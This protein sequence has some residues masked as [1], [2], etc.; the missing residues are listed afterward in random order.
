VR[1]RHHHSL[2]QRLFELFFSASFPSK[3]GDF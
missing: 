3:V 1:H 2:F